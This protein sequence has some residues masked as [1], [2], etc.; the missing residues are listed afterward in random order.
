[1]GVTELQL[2]AKD[3]YVGS[4]L[5][6]SVPSEALKFWSRVHDDQGLQVSSGITLGIGDPT[7]LALMAPKASIAHNGHLPTRCTIAA[8]VDLTAPKIYAKTEANSL[9]DPTSTTAYVDGQ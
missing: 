5:C 9:L 8:T 7:S 4:L 3:A 1:M 6:I 2:R